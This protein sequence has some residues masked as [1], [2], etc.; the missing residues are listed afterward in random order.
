M[1]VA[2][3]HH[4]RGRALLGQN[5]AEAAI[6]PLRAVVDRCPDLIAARLDLAV[7][8]IRAGF[9]QRAADTLRAGL[10]RAAAPGGRAPLW[11]ILGEA[12]TRAGDHPGAKDA[13]AQA[14]ADPSLGPRADD[15]LA[16][17]CARAGDYDAAFAHLL[18]AARGT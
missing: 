14:A 17:T 1:G 18:R 6:E 8:L 16:R 11:L 2:S 7:A 13:Y 9:A 12:L 4:R 5:D 10:A 3:R 15:G